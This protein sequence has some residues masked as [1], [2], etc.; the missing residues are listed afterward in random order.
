MTAVDQPG[1]VLT[2]RDRAILAAVGAGRAELSCSC[3]PDLFI[4]GLCFC[5]QQAAHRLVREG[6]IAAAAPGALGS[7]VAAI[8]TAIGGMLLS[9]SP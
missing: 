4:D 9:G 6:L 5:D 8:L 3:E 2:G 7:R 1:W